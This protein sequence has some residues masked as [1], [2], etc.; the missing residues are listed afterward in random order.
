MSNAAN[1][2]TQLAPVLAA[3]KNNLAAAGH[4]D[5]IG[6]VVADAG[7]WSTG[8]ATIATSARVLIATTPATN[9]D[10]QVGDPRLAIRS[11]VLQRLDQGE[12]TTK[13]AAAQI[14]VS[15]QWVR[16]LLGEYRWFGRDPAIVRAE[17]DAAL[18]E[19]DNAARYAKRKITVEPVFGQIKHNRGYRRFTRRGMAA[20]DSEWKLICAT[21]NLLKLR[22]HLTAAT[23]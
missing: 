22:R 14:G 4:A 19:P 16:H 12:L 2:T 18:A 8:N 13:A 23:G 5:G 20:V 6:S 17:M 10:I 3:A 21:G 1:D 15:Q 11:D 7:Y 9:G